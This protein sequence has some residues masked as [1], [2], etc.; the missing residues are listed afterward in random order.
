MQRRNKVEKEFNVSYK[1]RG[2][3]RM[4]TFVEASQVK[5]LENQGAEILYLARPYVTKSAPHKLA[6]FLHEGI[7]KE[8]TVYGHSDAEMCELVEQAFEG[9]TNITLTV[10][11]ND[12]NKKEQNPAALVFVLFAVIIMLLILPL[13]IMLNLFGKAE[14]GKKLIAKIRKTEYQKKT[15][16]RTPFGEK[17]RKLAIAFAIVAEV[18][19][20]GGICMIV[21]GMTGTMDS[22]LAMGV[23]EGLIFV[24]V[25]YDVLYL[26]LYVV[27]NKQG[28]LYKSANLD[29]EQET[30]Q[31][32]AAKLKQPITLTDK[33][34]QIYKAVKWIVLVIAVIVFVSYFA[35]VHVRQTSVQLESDT[36]S[37]SQE[38]WEIFES[39]E[40]FEQSRNGV[41]FGFEYFKHE[42]AAIVVVPFVI[43]IAA[44]VCAILSLTLKMT[45][46]LNRK[47]K[48]NPW[49]ISSTVLSCASAFWYFVL[50]ITFGGIS[51]NDVGDGIVYLSHTRVL[52]ITSIVFGIVAAGA[53]AVTVLSA[54]IKPELSKLNEIAAPAK[55][56]RL[57]YQSALATCIVLSVALF[58][59]GVFFGIVGV[60]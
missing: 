30:E 2:A 18:A 10:P 31:S 50:F 21:L 51:E 24:P 23:G 35:P 12:S 59:V 13:I 55:K 1:L 17:M 60:L 7:T 25:L 39:Y 52:N 15:V 14:G 47:G 41:L 19:L 48:F 32:V 16:I 53:I 33:A 57:T 58:A 37:W 40:Q 38:Q 3:E 34:P 26:V 45:N 27:F 36:T 42:L 22:Q 4:A 11:Q 56:G 6:T 8:V 54:A 28:K 46:G 20:V 29:S 49:L 5:D 44:V 43:A 9:A